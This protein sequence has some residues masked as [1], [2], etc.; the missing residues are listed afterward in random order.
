[1]GEKVMALDEEHTK[2]A[3]YIMLT[4]DGEDVKENKMTAE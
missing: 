3:H 4:D 1:V 2:N